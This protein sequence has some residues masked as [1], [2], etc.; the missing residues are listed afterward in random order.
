MLSIL[1]GSIVFYILTNDTGLY[2]AIIPL[3]ADK[4]ESSC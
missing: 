4:G 2:L 3:E 1:P